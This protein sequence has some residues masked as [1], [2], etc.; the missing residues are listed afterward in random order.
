MSQPEGQQ[1]KID[2][3]RGLLSLMTSPSII[4]CS[5][6]SAFELFF[7]LRLCIERTSPRCAAQPDRAELALRPLANL[8]I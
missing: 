4:I 2:R 6:A 1:T 5:I 7:N 3:Y 8:V